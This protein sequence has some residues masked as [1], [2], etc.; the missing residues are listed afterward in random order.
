[1]RVTEDGRETW[2][3]GDNGLS[4]CVTKQGGG[5]MVH[6]MWSRD[7]VN[8]IGGYGEGSPI[9]LEE[10]TE[11]AKKFVRGQPVPGQLGGYADNGPPAQC[12]E[13]DGYVAR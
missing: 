8:Y 2:Y 4:A 3:D 12:N 5:Y 6:A 1:M 7:G 13:E 11:L 10:A 9:P